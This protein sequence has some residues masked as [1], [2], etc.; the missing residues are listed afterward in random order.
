MRAEFR[1]DALAHEYT[2]ALT[3]E[4]LPHITGMLERAGYIDSEWYTP[5]SQARGIGVHRL[6]ADYDLGALDPA[7][8]DSVYRGWLLAHVAAMNALRPE[9]LAVEEPIV[10]P[11]YR[12]GGRPDR[13]WKLN[14]IVGVP[15]LKSG[16]PEKSHPIQTAL[17][18]ILVSTEV[19]L[20]AQS[21]A[22]WGLYLKSNGKWKLV[23]HTDPADFHRAFDLIRRFTRAGAA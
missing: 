22:R 17:Q 23:P 15:D 16:Q 11:V 3:G 20:P 21:I 8:C 5:A 12:Y 19:G 2:D 4:V 10:H 9:I 1:F 13:V 7:R 18:A 6:T 14:G